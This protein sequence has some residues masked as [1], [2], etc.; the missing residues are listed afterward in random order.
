[1][2]IDTTLKILA[3]LIR[4]G[5]ASST[6]FWLRH[7]AGRKC[8]QCTAAVCGAFCRLLIAL[9]CY[10]VITYPDE[11]VPERPLKNPGSVYETSSA[12][13]VLNLSVWETY[14]G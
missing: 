10:A 14:L 4:G 11:L 8:S 1:L 7:C 13:L 9:H 3:S 2:K 12:F 5:R 6:S